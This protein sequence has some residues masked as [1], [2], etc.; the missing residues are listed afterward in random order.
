MEIEHGNSPDQGGSNR[1][2]LIVLLIS[3]YTEVVTVCL[4][5]CV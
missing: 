4:R 3:L 1:S 2:L 5:V